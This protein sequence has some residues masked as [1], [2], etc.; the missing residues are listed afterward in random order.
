MKAHTTK[1]PHAE[2]RS[3]RSPAHFVF[4]LL[5][6][7][8]AALAD[9]SVRL[10]VAVKGE[11]ND[12][13]GSVQEVHRR[14]LEVSATA[15]HLERPEKVRIEWTLFGDDLTAKKVVK[16]ASGVDTVELAQGQVATSKTKPATFTYTP[17]HSVRTGSGRRARFKTVEAT[18]IRYHGWAVRAFI[19][20]QLAGEAYSIE[21]I[22][23]LVDGSK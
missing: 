23:K 19:G 21:S 6:T 10:R 11:H 3:Q 15:F 12:P 4:I 8:T 14:W 17:R 9:N 22:K 13:R 2:A 1:T 20:D 18:G 16:Q 7:A 5:T